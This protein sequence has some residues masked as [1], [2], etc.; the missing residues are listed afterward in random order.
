ML[1]S[2][3][4][5]LTRH[6][7]GQCPLLLTP[8]ASQRPSLHALKIRLSVRRSRNEVAWVQARGRG[9]VVGHLFLDTLF[10]TKSILGHP[11]SFDDSPENF[12]FHAQ[13]LSF[14]LIILDNGCRLTTSV[15]RC[16]ALRVF[17]RRISRRVVTLNE[18]QTYE[19]S[20][21]VVVAI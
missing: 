16:P 9:R 21:L 13:F 18:A 7:A 15:T 19:P 8:L 10:L 3:L 20:T 14:L 6:F 2:T 17:L 11:R 1:T 5:S 12:K 4:A